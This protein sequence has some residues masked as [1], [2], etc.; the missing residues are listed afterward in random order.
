MIRSRIRRLQRLGKYQSPLVSKSEQLIALRLAQGNWRFTYDMFARLERRLHVPEMIPRMGKDEYGVRRLQQLIVTIHAAIDFQLRRSTAVGVKNAAHCH[1]VN[2]AR[3]CG[4][5][6]HLFRTAYKSQPKRRAIGPQ[7]RARNT[8]SPVQV[9]NLAKLRKVIEVATPVRADG[10]YIDA[11]TLD[12]VDLLTFVFLDD[13]LIRKTR[14]TNVLDSLR[15]RLRYID[16]PAHLVE[17]VCR[18]TDDKVIAQ[19]LR[20]LQ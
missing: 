19:R 13:D 14:F 4:L 18:H 17:T 10:K 7:L 6:D 20:P 9:H 12:V 15:Q 16:F 3:L 8:L 1:A 11:K 2:V 5:F